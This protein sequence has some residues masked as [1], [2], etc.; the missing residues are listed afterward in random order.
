MTLHSSAPDPSQILTEISRLKRLFYARTTGTLVLL[1][2]FT[3]LADYSEQ[4]LSVSLPFTFLLWGLL[5]LLQIILFRFPRII[6]G[7]LLL[8]IVSDFTLIGLLVYNS[9]GIN[10]PIIF[11]LG[12]LIII[13]GTQARV[14]MVLI[15]AVLASTTYLISI[16]TYASRH[17]QIIQNEDTLHILLQISLFFLA[18]GIMAL[19]ARRH[20]NLQQDTQHTTTE[21]LRLQELHSQVMNAMQEGIVL[22]DKNLV[23]QDFNSAT[24]DILNTQNLRINNHLN[25]F[26]TTP[27]ELLSFIQQNDLDHFRTEIQHQQQSLLLTLSRLHENNASWLMTIINTTETRLLERQLAEQDKLASIGQMAAM[28]AHEIRNPMQTISQAVELMGL[29]QKDNRLETII[30]DEISRLNR[31]VS[32][33]L[34]YASPLHP[35]IQNVNVHA[36]TNSAIA[37]ADLHNVFQIKCDVPDININVDP[38]HFRLVIDNLLRNALLASPKQASINIVFQ[39]QRDGWNLSI[40][41]H[42]PGIDKALRHKLFDPFQTGRKE[43]TGLGLATVWQVCQINHW[44]VRVDESFKD[45]TCFVVTSETIA[46][47][48]DGENN[49]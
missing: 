48:Q 33:M 10:S 23:I 14:L 44:S 40:K 31:L 16:H 42:G 25:S 5:S 3:W 9:G 35:H 28:L 19:I 32:D 47:S 29:Q 15:S 11:L 21:N 45:G 26:L 2:L 8:Q 20:A 38:D 49:G 30:S 7:N 12:V 39:Q 24:K 22:L 27:Q 34:N 37:Q 43:G 36:L 13:A 4:A 1:L 46:L 17:Q 6:I 41:D 18:G